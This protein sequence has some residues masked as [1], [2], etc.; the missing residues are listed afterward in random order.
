MTEMASHHIT[1]PAPPRALDLITR[2]LFTL[3]TGLLLLI[4]ALIVAQV[5]ARNLWN[6][7]LPRAEEISRLAGVLAVYCTAP[8]LALHGQ[9]VAVD[10]FTN[11]MPRTPRLA[12]F[13]LAELSMLAFAALT[14]WGG[15][16]Y[17][18]RAWKFR[19]P[20]L[21]MQNIWLFGPVLLCIALLIVIALWRILA[22]LRAERA[23]R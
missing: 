17:L 16:L 13:V 6:T 3:A 11:L 9:H 2:G 10:V 8:L 1:A 22:V 23:P 7:G 5:L 14:I 21:G 4:I 15:W 18:D 20:A 12:C 19:T